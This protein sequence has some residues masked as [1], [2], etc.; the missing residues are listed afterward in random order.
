[1][2]LFYTPAVLEPV[3]TFTE[4]ESRHCVQVLRLQEGNEVFLTDGKGRLYR[5]IIRSAQPK[6]CVVEVLE[7]QEEY[8]K[9][10]YYLHVAIAPTKNTDRF[11]WFLEKA[12]EVGIDEITPLICKRSERRE[13]KTERLNKV[14][15][16]AMKQSLKA[17]HP[18]L[19]EPCSFTD[20]FDKHKAEHQLIAHCE[21][22]EKRHLNFNA[23][24]NEV[25]VLI[26]PEGDFTPEEIKKAVDKGFQPISLGESRLRTETAAL[27]VCFYMQ[28]LNA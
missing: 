4:E 28:F 7:V 18:Q 3:Y 27:S 2:H 20:F 24:L 17:Y 15:T 13:V 5:T 1:M 16:A 10:N 22:G 26:G 14:I 12:T 9:R 25:L 8:G 6:K 23:R 21:P 11:E 19:N